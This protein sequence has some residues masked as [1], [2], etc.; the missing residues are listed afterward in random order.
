[1]GRH[2]FDV[3]LTF[4]GEDRAF[5]EQI[6]Q[7]LKASGIAVFYD[8]FEQAKLWGEDLSVY[9]DEV[10]RQKSRYV[11]LF[12]STH[13]I[14]KV[15]TSHERR[16]AQARAIEERGAAYL[17][18]VRLDDSPIPGLPPTIAFIDG[19]RYS[20]SQISTLLVEKLGKSVDS[21]AQ[22]EAAPHLGV[23]LTPDEV[24]AVITT[25]PQKWEYLLLAGGI[26]QSVKGL[27]DRAL[28]HELGYAPN[29]GIYIDSDQI[30]ELIVRKLSE[31]QGLVTKLVRVI[32]KEAQIWALGE[33]GESGDP[34]RIAQLSKRFGSAYGEILEWA[35]GIRGTTTPEEYSNLLYL[36]SRYAD[37]A[38]REVRA[39][40]ERFVEEAGRI[41]IFL[42]SHASTVGNL[43]ITLRLDIDID[44]EVCREFSRERDRL[45]LT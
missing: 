33:P 10:Y 40:A 34:L 32:S 45:L 27:E 22:V 25:R 14:S 19:R 20:P 4:A 2:E 13:Y 29:N 17:L 6:A 41:P 1:M 42:N 9:L 5:V 26:W 11:V 43:A 30:S 31:L 36:L 16:S 37:A 18:P 3:A 21:P 28:D 44:S 38:I 24:Q 8:Q 35:S 39:F 12:G 15:W 23:P 7:A